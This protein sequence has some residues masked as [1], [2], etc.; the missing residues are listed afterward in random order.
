M[1]LEGSQDGDK[2]GC[3]CWQALSGSGGLVHHPQQCTLRDLR[4]GKPGHW[5][6]MLAK[7]YIKEMIF[8][9]PWVLDLPIHRKVLNSLRYPVFFNSS[10]DV[11]TTF[12]NP[13][14]SWLLPYLFRAV[15]QSDLRGCLL[16]L[17]SSENCWI[18]ENSQLSGCA[19]FV[20]FSFQSAQCIYFRSTFFNTLL[21]LKPVFQ[22]G[23]LLHIYPFHNYFL[24]VSDNSSNIW[25]LFLNK[26]YN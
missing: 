26:N 20:F 25:Y 22:N 1:N 24:D 4:M 13:Y 7:V 23:Q 6:S 16:G 12:K 21:N 9:E 8:S 11:P 17:K 14:I 2:W 5:L 18:K 15:P 19:F 3:P 10:F